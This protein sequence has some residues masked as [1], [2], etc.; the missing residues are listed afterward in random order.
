MGTTEL[1]LILVFLFLYLFYRAYTYLTDLILA[2]WNMYLSYGSY[3]CFTEHILVLQILY[4]AYSG[5]KVLV[6]TT[7]IPYTEVPIGT[8]GVIL[9]LRIREYS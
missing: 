9:I 2:L 3:T 5:T 8:I 6:G 7:Q 1:I 4:R